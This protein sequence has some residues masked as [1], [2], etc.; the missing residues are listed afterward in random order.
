MQIHNHHAVLQPLQGAELEDLHTVD[1]EAHELKM[2]LASANRD[3]TRIILDQMKSL[4][5]RMP[6]QGR[7]A[8]RSAGVLQAAITQAEQQLEAL[9]DDE[10]RRTHDDAAVRRLFEIAVYSTMSKDAKM[11]YNNIEH[12]KTY[13]LVAVAPGGKVEKTIEKE[14]EGEHLRRHFSLLKF[15]SMSEAEKRQVLNETFGVDNAVEQVANDAA[16]LKAERE[17]LAHLHDALKDMEAYRAYISITHSHGNLRKVMVEIALD[18]DH[19]QRAHKEV[20]ALVQAYD[21]V[22]AAP[23]DEGA[24]VRLVEARRR[25]K[26]TLKDDIIND[27][28][29]DANDGGVQP[30]RAPG[31]MLSPLTPMLAA[32][33]K[34]LG[35]KS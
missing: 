28:L 18:H 35:V 23:D 33:G 31:E 11:F 13:K 8:R 32:A 26:K 1:E 30:M 25:M 3:R 17:E 4:A 10:Y 9:N 7:K 16:K 19:F 27:V 29:L 24:K 2:A 21:A 5:G 20:D 14:V 22:L 12:D 15:H 34:L 6:T